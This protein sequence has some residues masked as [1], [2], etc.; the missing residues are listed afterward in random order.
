M[1][2]PCPLFVSFSKTKRKTIVPSILCGIF[3]IE[4][5]HY[6][7]TIKKVGCNF[8]IYHAFLYHVFPLYVQDY[9]LKTPSCP[10]SCLKTNPPV[11]AQV[12]RKFPFAGH[13]FDAQMPYFQ[14][15]K[16]SEKDE[17]GRR[18]E[19]GVKVC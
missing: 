9:N 15:G 11:F 3:V 18:R 12:C 1:C 14:V 7:L 17:D 2:T 8:P 10:A 16:E 5:R 4:G 13:Q 19:K 6:I